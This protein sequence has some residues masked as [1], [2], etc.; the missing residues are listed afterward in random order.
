MSPPE[1]AAPVVEEE[2][3]AAIPDED[4]PG[5]PLSEEE[6]DEAF[7]VAQKMAKFE[8]QRKI[9]ESTEGASTTAAAF[10]K[11]IEQLTEGLTS[12]LLNSAAFVLKAVDPT[13]GH[14]TGNAF[15]DVARTLE[16]QAETAGVNSVLAS[17]AA[18]EL[19]RDRMMRQT[20]L[21]LNK[22]AGNNRKTSDVKGN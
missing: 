13:G 8:Q 11:R 16:G 20:S 4:P 5:E 15:I 14:L 21:Q 22:T 2:E 3:I 9:A 1:A 10:D 18:S 19:D 7:A 17:G 6:A 12:I